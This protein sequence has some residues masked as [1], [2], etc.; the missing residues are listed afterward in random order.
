MNET[1]VYV[2][3]RELVYP[4]KLIGENVHC[5]EQCVQVG[6]NVYAT[7]FGLARISG[8]RISV[9]P[10]AG[11]Y[12]P[13]E[14]DLV[15]GV[16]EEVRMGHWN[17]DIQTPYRTSIM[18]E[19]MTRNPLQEDLKKYFKVGEILSAKVQ[20]VNE[21][22]TTMLIRP[23]KLEGGRIIHVNPKRVPRIIG[24]KRSMLDLLK[25]KTGCNIVVGQNGIIWI[26]GNGMNL[27]VT[28][29]KKIEAEAQT[30]GLTDR[31]NQML[32]KKTS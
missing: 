21:Q 32:D 26:K 3:D 16:V 23:W 5:D 14:N 18:G 31:I 30:S 24:K 8:D 13:K 4:G 28:A 17:V 22:K 27:C 29:I 25:G 2:G 19:E 10:S 1:K 20:D 7:V 9:I 12:T 15:V 6:N 11:G